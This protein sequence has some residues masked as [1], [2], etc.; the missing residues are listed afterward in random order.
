[1]ISEDTPLSRDRLD[2]IYRE[3]NRPEFIS[4]DPLE[5][6][7]AYDNVADREIAALLAASMAYGRV[8]SLLVSLKKVLTVMGPSPAEY[9]RHRTGSEMEKDLEGIVHRFARPPH[10]ASLLAGTG[11]AVRS[12]G[13]LEAAF[14]QGYG[15]ASAGSG[16]SQAGLKS[17]ESAIRHGAVRDPGHLLVDPA[18]GS[19]CKRLY[20]FL[21]WMVRHDAVDPGGWERVSTADLMLPLDTWTHRIALRA[22][23]TRRKTADLTTVREVSGALKTMNPEDP[24]RYDFALSRFGIRSGLNLD[25][26]FSAPQ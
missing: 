7:G 3:W 18:K 2:D 17:L 15:T 11:A 20:L 1:M 23:W 16:S 9:V 12:Y 24:I 4:P 6:L 22:G 5:T 8:A 25:L 14:L 26:L 19:A 10:L 13:S 21:R